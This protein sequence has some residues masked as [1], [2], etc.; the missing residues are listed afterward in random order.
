MSTTET[1]REFYVGVDLG[2]TKILAGIFDPE[3]N[4][5]GRLKLST[6][7]ARGPKAVIERIARCVIE[8]IDECDLTRD[9]IKAVGLG[10]PGACDPESGRVINAPN[11]GWENVPLKKELEAS[12]GLPVFVENDCTVCTLGVFEVELQAKPRHVVGIFLGTGVGGG[13][14]LDG[15]LYGGFNGTAGEIG[16]MVLQADGPKCSCGNRGC[17]EALAGRGALFRRIHAAV[18]AGQ[19]TLLTDLCGPD[20]KDLRSGDLRRAIRRGDQFVQDLVDEAARHTGL[21]VANLINLLSP[22][23]VVVGGGLIEALEGEMMP[24]IS[25]TAKEHALAGTAKGIRIV[26][27]LLGDDAGITGAAV[28]ARRKAG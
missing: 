22:E 7:P 17:F 1:K 10:A 14:I 27:S 28:L 4:C 11:L 18:K 13:L 2:G 21:A 9:T 6:K 15:Q 20:L 16:H 5:I 12:L 26:P 24:I 23:I 25:R 3:L 8:A 19:A